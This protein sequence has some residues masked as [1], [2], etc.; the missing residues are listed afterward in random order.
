MA[1]IADELDSEKIISLARERF[2]TKLTDAEVRVLRGDA[3]DGIETVGSERPAN[4]PPVRAELIHWLATDRQVSSYIDSSGIMISRA[5][6]SGPLGLL[7]CKI[8]F[9]LSFDRCTF[10]GGIYLTSASTRDVFFGNCVT[11]HVISAKLLHV[12]GTLI[13]KGFRSAG[14]IDLSGAIIEGDLGVSD[15]SLDSGFEL[16]SAQVN[17]SVIFNSVQ[18]GA[19]INMAAT[20][21]RGALVFLGTVFESS[22][23]SLDLSFTEIEQTVVLSGGFSS[24]SPISMLSARIGGD[25]LCKGAKLA[26]TGVSMDLTRCTVSGDV[27]FQPGVDQRFESAGTVQ[28]NGAQIGGSLLCDGA[29]MRGAGIALDLQIVNI[30]HNVWLRDQFNA[31]GTVRI[32]ASKIGADLDCNDSVFGGNINAIYLDRS[33]VMQTVFLRGSS[34]S[35]AIRLISTHVGGDIDCTEASLG[36]LECRDLRVDGDFFWTGMQR[37][38]SGLHLN[39]SSVKTYHDDRASWPTPG[40]LSIDGFVY[41]DLILH[42][43]A[44]RETLAANGIEPALDLSAEERISWL[45]LQPVS[46]QTRPQPWAQLA[47]LFDAEGDRDGAKLIRFE[48]SRLQ[49]ER[50]P[51]LERYWDIGY[52]KLHEDPGLITMPLALLWLTGYTVFWRARRM[53]AMAPSDQHAYEI[54]IRTNKLPEHYVAY[55]PEA[56]VL[57]NLLPVVKLGQDSAWQ[58]N[59]NRPKKEKGASEADSNENMEQ[60]VEEEME[61]AWTRWMPVPSYRFL[62][63]FRWALII[64]GWILALIFTAAVTESFKP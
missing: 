25:L 28:M 45:M 40:T 43:P 22:G 13:F 53:K 47:K 58:P 39:S 16:S 7:E 8:P 2:D 56:Y 49:A 19:S 6:I 20:K 32:V 44:T 12:E 61:S 24:K 30:R 4:P 37:P 10:D 3:A 62:A 27:N 34:A 1:Q 46:E 17:G 5:R 64:L 14:P 54:Y 11:S 15:T 50:E 48:F 18:I 60:E 51:I 38:S 36:T 57:E 31:N 9:T 59:R 29:R 33:E 26:A 23:G 42:Q 63:V 35:G 55:H 52:A 21:I 41:D